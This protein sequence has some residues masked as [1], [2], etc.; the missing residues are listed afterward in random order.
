MN[1]EKFLEYSQKE[2]S[3]LRNL[4]KIMGSTDNLDIFLSRVSNLIKLNIKSRYVFFVLKENDN[5]DVKY[6]EILAKEIREDF[7][8]L[9]LLIASDV[10]RKGG[11]LIINNTKKHKRLKSFNIKNILV[12]SLM[13]YSDI[14]GAII[15][16]QKADGFSRADLRLV[17][18]IGNQVAIGIEKIKMKKELEKKERKVTK[19]YA[20]LYEK[21]SKRAISDGLTGLYNK[22][23]FIN[24]LEEFIKEKKKISLIM[25]DLDYFKN[26]NDIYGHLAGDELLKQVGLTIKTI[27]N[28]YEKY[29]IK[30]LAA[31]YGGEEFAIIVEAPLNIAREIAETIRQEI[32]DFYYKNKAKRYIT[33]SFGVGE[34]KEK[35]KASQFIERVD[36]LLYKS[37]QLG[38]NIV[39]FD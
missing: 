22:T 3:I 26:Y 15:L 28:N 8:D 35:E 34:V 23:Y 6:Y 31:R 21:E 7:K 16:L 11:A 29:N 10:M 36:K 18:S 27:L 25:F 12:T 30:S 17:N 19:L 13:L 20:K 24:K 14:I 33:A 38:K 37:K 2:I 1:K 4:Y 5:L 9:L 39:L 32:E